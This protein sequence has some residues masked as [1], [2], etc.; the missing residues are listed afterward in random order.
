MKDYREA[1]FEDS[2][3]FGKQVE[4]YVLSRI[5][6]K[7]PKAFIRNG[8]HK[9]WD[10][11]VPDT[12]TKIEVKSDVRSNKTGNFVIETSYGGRPSALTTST[13]DFWVFFDGYQLIWI[14][15]EGIKRAI[16]ES[17]AE[18]KEFTGGTDRKSK[19]AFLVN[20]Y[21][22]EQN[23]VMIEKPLEDL[24]SNFKFNQK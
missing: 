15:K 17:G 5:R 24:P 6:K 8:Y 21:F 4:E 18:L 13:A 9:E 1:R 23:A 10:I 12:K 19:N 2:L 20:R 3:E 11:Y 16:K 22:I 14:T 7:Y